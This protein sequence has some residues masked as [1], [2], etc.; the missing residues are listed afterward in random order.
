MKLLKDLKD[1]ILAKHFNKLYIFFGEDNGLRKHYINKIAESYSTV[2]MIDSLEQISTTS[3]KGGLFKTKT[4]YLI[5]ND[6]QCLKNNLQS[7]T[8][9]LNRI[10]DDC[11][12]VDFESL[13]ES[14]NLMKECPDLFT[15]FTVVNDNIG[16]EFV[17][18]IIKVSS[19]SK[20]ELVKNCGNNYA[21]ILLE[22][23]KI[24]NYSENQNVSNEV[25]YQDLKVKEQLLVKPETFDINIIMDNILT[26]NKDNLANIYKLIKQN[27]VE[28]L[29]FSLN[30]IFS[31]YLICYCLKAFGYYDGSTIAYNLQLP[32]YRTKALRDYNLPYDSSYYLW[33]ANEI[34]QID[35][36]VKTGKMNMEDILDYIFYTLI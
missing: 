15:K 27:Y 12:I 34:T 14:C 31:D 8:K 17:D 28:N 7:I 3:S 18:D 22:T 35:Y 23:D 25:A 6:E 16:L 9:I 29:W 11:V 24:L 30:R 21:N 10:E 19:K 4:L 13:D 32:W 5:Y 1:E 33:C 36:K 26:V 20:K 2:R